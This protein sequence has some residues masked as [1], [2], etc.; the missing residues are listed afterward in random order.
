MAFSGH[1]AHLDPHATDAREPAQMHRRDGMRDLRLMR[2]EL[3]TQDVEL[4]LG[5]V[6]MVAVQPGATRCPKP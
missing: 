5:L 6:E 1:F 2:R 3:A 4:R